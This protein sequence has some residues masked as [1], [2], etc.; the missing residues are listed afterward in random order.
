MTFSSVSA[1]LSWLNE[2]FPNPTSPSH[3]MIFC[4]LD[5]GA[6]IN[7]ISFTIENSGVI[8]TFAVAFFFFHK[9]NS[10]ILVEVG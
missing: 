4:S 1:L 9:E 3:D 8:S 7:F 6:W 2:N 5:K 10:A